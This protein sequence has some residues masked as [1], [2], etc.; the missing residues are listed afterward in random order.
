[1]RCPVCRGATHPAM[2]TVTLSSGT[3]HMECAY[4]AGEYI[5]REGKTL[6]EAAVLVRRDLR[7]AERNA[8]RGE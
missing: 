7:A 8:L 4:R 5:R 1:M 3:Y 2:G 6:S